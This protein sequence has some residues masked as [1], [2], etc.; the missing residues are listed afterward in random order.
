M[1]GGIVP[2]A[3]RYKEPISGTNI[4]DRL[5]LS[6]EPMAKLFTVVIE[7]TFQIHGMR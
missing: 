7:R 5:E 6:Y 4:I 3:E 1:G 2:Q